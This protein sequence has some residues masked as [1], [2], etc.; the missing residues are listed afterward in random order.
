MISIILG[1]NVTATVYL[2]LKSHKYTINFSA[3]QTTDPMMT[4]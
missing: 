2:L 3:T 1:Y 4:V